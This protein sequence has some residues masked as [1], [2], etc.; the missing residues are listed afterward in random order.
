MSFLSILK[1]INRVSSKIIKTF[2][3]AC[4]SAQV[5]IV[6]LGVFF[7]YVLSNPLSWTEEF[8]TYLMIYLTFFGCFIALDEKKLAQINIFIKNIKN[9][10]YQRLLL[11]FG[12]LVTTLF[13]I[14]FMY[15]G[16]KLFFSFTVQKQHSIAMGLPMKVYYVSIPISAAL[17]IN[18]L[19]IS[20][21]EYKKEDLGG[22]EEWL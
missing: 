17:I 4:I 7:R 18:R 9:Y 8:S 5:I 16:T 12:Y 20:M 15:Y 2:L 14:F 21:I 22:N 10:K 11:L 13:M 6:F 1:E 19:I 3:V